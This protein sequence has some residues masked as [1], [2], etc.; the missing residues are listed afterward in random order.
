M[1]KKIEKIQINKVRA[2]KEDIATNTTN[3]N[4]H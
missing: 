3:K 1:N 4:D 2:E